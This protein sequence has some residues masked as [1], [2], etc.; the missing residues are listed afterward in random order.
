MVTRSVNSNQ[1]TPLIDWEDAHVFSAT[2][3]GFI[4]LTW[5]GKDDGFLGAVVLA[6]WSLLNEL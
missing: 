1:S 5:S 6:T 2:E 4:W 3:E